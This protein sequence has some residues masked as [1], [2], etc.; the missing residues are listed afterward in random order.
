MDN[1]NQH[2]LISPFLAP[3][4]LPRAI[5]LP[6]EIVEQALTHSFSTIF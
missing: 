4:Q 5:L 3:F 1:G 2:N 6:K